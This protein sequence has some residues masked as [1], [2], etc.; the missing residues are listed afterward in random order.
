VYGFQVIEYFA[1]VV[2]SGISSDEMRFIASS[3]LAVV[4]LSCKELSRELI[5]LEV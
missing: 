3:G 1:A 5:I 4:I 2:V